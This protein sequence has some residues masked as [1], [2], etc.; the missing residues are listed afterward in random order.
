MVTQCVLCEVVTE[1][2]EYKNDNFSDCHF[3][4]QRLP[5]KVVRAIRDFPKCLPI[6]DLHVA[7]KITRR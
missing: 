1:V 2:F 5:T 7:L 4:I 6:Y 3:L